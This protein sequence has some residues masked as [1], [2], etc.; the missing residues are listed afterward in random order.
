[1]D[2]TLIDRSTARRFKKLS[3]N[4]DQRLLQ[5]WYAELYAELGRHP[6][7][8]VPGVR[9][10]FSSLLA[11]PAMAVLAA[12]AA[13]LRCPLAVIGEVAARS[14]PA[15]VP[16]AG[17]PFPVIG[18]IAWVGF[19]GAAALAGSLLILRHVVS[20]CDGWVALIFAMPWFRAADHKVCS[21]V[22]PATD[23]WHQTWAGKRFAW[24]KQV[25]RTFL[26]RRRS[27]QHGDG[28]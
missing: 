12:L 20:P 15:F 8:R 13:G 4:R 11:P 16:S 1:M 26:C 28:L 21:M 9:Q 23:Q 3:N 14:L 5:P 19:L 2:D 6:A 22:L 17:G 7:Q 24:R 10:P 18:E 27:Q 25:D